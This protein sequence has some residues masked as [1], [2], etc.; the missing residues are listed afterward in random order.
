MDT[1][2][3]TVVPSVDEAREFFEIANDFAEPLE[4]V[5][6]AISNAHDW[7]A[8]NIWITFETQRLEGART[9]IVRFRDDGTGMSKQ[10]VSATFWGLGHSESRG[11]SQKIGEKGH[12]TKIFL[13]SEKVRVST[14]GPDGAFAAECERPFRKLCNHELHAPEWWEV[15]PPNDGKTF[16][17]IEL[18]GY[19]NNA[20]GTFTQ[21]VV[22]D[23][24]LWCTKAGSVEKELTGQVKRELTVHLKGLDVAEHEA[25]PHGH[26][27]PPEAADLN[28]LFDRYSYDAADYFVKRYHK[29]DVL[30]DLPDVRYEAV[31]YV[32]GDLAK[33]AYNP[34]IK[35][36][37]RKGSDGYKVGD[38]YG[39]WLCKDYIPVCR[40]NEWI[41][42]FGT[43]GNAWV[44]LH[45]FVNCQELNLTANRGTFANTDPQVT[46][47]LKIAIAEVVEAVDRDILKNQL[48]ALMNMQEEARTQKQ[49][50]TDYKSRVKS[51]KYRARASIDDQEVLEPQNEAELFGLFMRVYAKHPDL[52][53]FLPCDYNTA[54]GIDMI[55]R[56]IGNPGV[57]ELPH[58]YVE[59]K[60]RLGHRNFNH[61]F[62]NLRWVVCWDFT[63]DCED[64]FEL[65]SS[66]DKTKRRIVYPTGDADASKYY[67][68]AGNTRTKIQ[69]IR[70]KCYLEEKLDVRFAQAKKQ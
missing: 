53:E 41:S 3:H 65:E 66:V 67:L 48:Y 16:T 33:R 2:R 9:L 13:N 54:R 26:P 12:G 22:K 57:S 8:S 42:S 58:G 17:E 10:A 14:L 40:V 4:A 47:G 62:T 5:R 24:V 19:N 46:A 55:A 38:R 18:Q 36:R 70:L 15:S 25:L 1:T 31:I 6:E 30:Q 28:K 20:S 68:D 59:F 63:D 50:E 64:G 23:Y 32:E 49:E 60:H 51:I 7:E 27:F 56:S 35:Q 44:L 69:V 11:D 29:T 61:G 39:I 21:R 45:G 43:G 37:L 34:M 52:F